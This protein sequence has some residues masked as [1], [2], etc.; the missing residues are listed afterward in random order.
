MA[1][2]GLVNYDENMVATRYH[3]LS[4]KTLLFH[5]LKRTLVFLLD[6]NIFKSVSVDVSTTYSPNKQVVLGY[7]VS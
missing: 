3:F 5:S 1:K 7:H 6:C 2:K 4:K